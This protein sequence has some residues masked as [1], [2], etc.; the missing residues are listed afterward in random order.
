MVSRVFLNLNKRANQVFRD[1]NADACS[2]SKDVTVVSTGVMGE[3]QDS[4]GTD[5]SD[6]VLLATGMVSSR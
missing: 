6:M 5:A 2:D 4:T 3:F 1:G